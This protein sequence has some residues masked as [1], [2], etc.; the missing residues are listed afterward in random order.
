MTK[1]IIF[2]LFIAGT[3]SFS[4]AAECQPGPDDRVPPIEEGYGFCSGSGPRM[5]EFKACINGQMI[6]GYCPSQPQSKCGMSNTVVQGF[7]Y[8]GQYVRGIGCFLTDI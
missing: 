2:A 1:F 6:T 7:M 3:I 4:K 8:Q 5:G